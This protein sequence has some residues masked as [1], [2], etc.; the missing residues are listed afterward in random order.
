VPPAPPSAAPAPGPPRT[1][2]GEALGAAILAAADALVAA[3][4]RLTEL[5][6]AVGDGDLGISLE[7]GVRAVREAL[8]SYPLDDPAAALHALGVTLQRSLG[9]TSGPLYAA[10][11]LRAAGALRRAGGADDPR[12][13]AEAFHAGCAAVAELG[14]AARGDRTMLDALLPAADALEATLRSGRPPAE[15]IRSAAEAAAEGARATAGMLP[16]RGRSSYL[17][18]RVLGHPDPGAE[19]VAVWLAALVA[20]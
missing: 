12:S 20:R 10:F 7:R 13:W 1:R 3:A 14:G 2:Q 15:A 9:G 16:R 11:L 5:D 19:A 17:G 8:P 6:R 4:P 18:E